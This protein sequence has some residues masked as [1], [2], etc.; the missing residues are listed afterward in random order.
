[1]RYCYCAECDRLQ[2]MSWH[3]LGRCEFCGKECQTIPVKRS[4]YGL[5]M[6]VLDAIAAILLIL[7]LAWDL[8]S[9]EAFSF[10]EDIDRTLFF[11]FVFGLI[12]ISFGLA[13]VDIGITRKEAEEK[14]ANLRRKK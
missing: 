7:Y 14:V 13:Y 6:Y 3:S 11:I 2:P 10:I 4:S 5:Y 1:V 8:W 9:V 12:F